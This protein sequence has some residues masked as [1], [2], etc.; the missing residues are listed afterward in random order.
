MK[1][2]VKFK[3]LDRYFFGGEK[4]FG[5]SDSKEKNKA[6]YF[7]RS[8]FMPSVSTVLGALRYEILCQNNL[9]SFSK[10]QEKEVKALI[11][12][13]GF[14]MNALLCEI[15]INYGIISAISPVF[16][17]DDSTDT[18]YTAMPVNYG[19]NKSECSAK[20][21]FSGKTTEKVLQFGIRRFKDYDNFEHWINAN[22]ETLSV[23][24]KK[25][26]PEDKQR[27]KL[28][29]ITEQIGIIKDKKGEED[30]EAFFKQEFITLHPDLSFA[31]TLK[32][33]QNLNEGETIVYLGANRSAF[34][35]A[36]QAT[37]LNFTDN[38]DGLNYF[39]KLQPKDGSKLLLGDAY[40]S[41][42]LR[43]LV[44]FIWGQSVCFRYIRK[45]TNQVSWGKPDKGV[46][47][48]LQSRGSVMYGAIDPLLDAYPNLKKVGMNIYL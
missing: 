36:I 10:N 28:Y 41:D 33:S 3:P 25:R 6:N 39:Q 12:I 30:K 9:L 4:T 22:N 14:D 1:Y 45:K 46:L 34:V 38:K 16:I 35:L 5:E 44:D 7:A 31:C 13:H 26:Y 18:Y 37:D 47:Y 40:I 29:T 21:Y 24:L 23:V 11:G 20:A 42:E 8:N 19:V 17:A 2:I 48:R 43:R 32:T 27:Q 15:P